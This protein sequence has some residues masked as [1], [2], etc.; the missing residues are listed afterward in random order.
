MVQDTFIHIQLRIC[1]V[2]TYVYVHVDAHVYMYMQ[3]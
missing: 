1:S 2:K 3:M